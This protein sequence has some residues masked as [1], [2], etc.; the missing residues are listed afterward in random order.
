V[1]AAPQSILCQSLSAQHLIVNAS[2]LVGSG[3]TIFL[4]LIVISQFFYYS[5]ARKAEGKIFQD[6]GAADAAGEDTA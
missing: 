6:D 5:R 1:L 4:D 3:G 2:W